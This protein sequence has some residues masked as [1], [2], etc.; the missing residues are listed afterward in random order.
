MAETTAEIDAIN[1]LL[2]VEK[3]ASTLINDAAQ[4]AE[5]RLS[6]ARAQYN[7]EYKA[8][9]DK[10]AGDLEAQYLENQKTIEK[11]YNDELEAYKQSLAAKPQNFE[12]FSKLLDTLVAQ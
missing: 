3:N 12:S 4:E 10:A 9:Y 1:H 6:A 8:G 11:K 5:R 7:S 2:E